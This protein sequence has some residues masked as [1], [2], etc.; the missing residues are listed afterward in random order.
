FLLPPSE[1]YRE[2][3]FRLLNARRKSNARAAV[4]ELLQTKAP[5]AYDTLYQESMQFATV[6]E[7]D[8]RLWLKEWE[9]SGLIRF[10]NWKANQKV[11]N[12][13]NTVQLI[14]SID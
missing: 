1:T 9:Q 3:R 10:R 11:P 8:L 2:K 5:I 13:E 7:D 12:R 6:V 4:I 14:G